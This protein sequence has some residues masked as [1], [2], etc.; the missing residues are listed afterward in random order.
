VVQLVGHARDQR[1]DHMP[2]R[3][4]ITGATDDVTTPHDQEARRGVAVV[5]NQHVE[6]GPLGAAAQVFEG[7]LGSVRA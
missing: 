7:D 6:P 4:Q 1:Y 2:Q 3:Q 5:V